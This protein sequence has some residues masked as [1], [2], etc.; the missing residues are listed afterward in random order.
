MNKPALV[1]GDNRPYW[2]VPTEPAHL[3]E[4]A[5]NMREHDRHEVEATGVGLKRT[6]WRSYRNSVNCRTAIVSVGSDR[7]VAAV[8]GLAI[9][10][11]NDISPLSDLGVPW[12][13][14]TAAV[15]KL[16]LAFVKEARS[17]VLAMLRLKQRLEL[18]VLA[19]YEKALRLVRLIGFTVGETAPVG[20]QGTRFCHVSLARSEKAIA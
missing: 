8:W 3:A 18:Y 20:P 5:A 17:E 6:L 1:H 16:P 4:L 10:M 15:E 14:T 19:D 2:I 11:R 12:L 7:L 9:G 13:L